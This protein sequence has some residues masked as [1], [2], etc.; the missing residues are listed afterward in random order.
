MSKKYKIFLSLFLSIILVIC[1]IGIGFYEAMQ[2]VTSY[3]IPKRDGVYTLVEGASARKVAD[4]LLSDSHYLPIVYLW[5]KKNPKLTN[6]QAGDYLVDGTKTFPELLEDMVKGNVVEKVYPTVAIVEGSTFNT[7]LN[8]LKKSGLDDPTFYKSI[9]NPKALLEDVFAK[10]P[11]LLEAIG[12]PKDSLEG[13]LMPAT[14]PMPDNEPFMTVLRQSLHKMAVFMKDAWARRD[15]DIILKDPYEALILASIVERETLLA[16]E[17]PYVAAVFYNRL[18]KKM[19]LQTDP[20][21]M[22]GISPSFSGKLTRAQLNKD[23]AYNTYTRVG[24]TPTPISM[25]QESSIDAVLHPAKSKALYFVAKDFSPTSGHVFSET[26]NDHN[27]AVAQYRAKVRAYKK[28]QAGLEREK[29]NQ[30]K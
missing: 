14:Y 2:S 24:L 9:E 27:K 19:R 16:S 6:I 10:E 15:K 1:I 7:L 3:K 11:E 22:Y 12:G 5:L 21:V 13:L 26:L 25:P 30:K 8:K 29:Q 20:T 17:R 23:T 28:E 4:D 18:K